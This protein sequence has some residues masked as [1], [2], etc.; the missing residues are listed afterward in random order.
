MPNIIEGYA[1]QQ[2]IDIFSLLES[3][4]GKILSSKTNVFR[5][6]SSDPTPPPDLLQAPGSTYIFWNNGWI[7]MF[8]VSKRPYRSAWHDEIIC[9]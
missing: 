1:A 4:I 9:K 7:L 2:K 8:K 5:S 6:D 3:N